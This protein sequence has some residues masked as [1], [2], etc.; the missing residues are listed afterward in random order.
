MRWTLIALMAAGCY[1]GA[2]PSEP[3]PAR[4]GPLVVDPP[5]PTSSRDAPGAGASLILAG[6]SRLHLDATR[7]STVDRICVQDQARISV[8]GATRIE[9]SSD[10]TTVIGGAGIGPSGTTP[11]TIEIAARGAPDIFVLFDNRQAPI[12]AVFDAP[13]STVHVGL[14]GQT[15][16]DLQGR[17][18]AMV[19]N[20]GWGLPPSFP[21]CDATRDR[22]VAPSFPP[23]QPAP[24]TCAGSGTASNYVTPQAGGAAEL[25]VIG[26]YEGDRHV[27]GV[28]EVHV[29]RRRR[30]VVLALTAYQPTTW[31]IDADARLAA[32]LLYG[33]EAQ[34]LEGVPR[35]VPV[36][37]GTRPAFACAYGWEPSQNTGG[38]SYQKMIAAV[39]KATG[40]VESSFQGC[41]AGRAFEIP[42]AR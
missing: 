18:K 22:D 26:A 24:Q 20:A 41:Y 10:Q 8:D 32:I 34:R 35:N 40:L 39:R 17:A 38:C 31:R 2:A 1:R 12:R 25:H 5:G 23:S 16:L 21:T 13:N 11:V 6:T 19:H 27:D 37:R 28:I 29:P 4:P 3:A 42:V 15:G 33:Y 30:P 14:T 7:G 36:K 9:L